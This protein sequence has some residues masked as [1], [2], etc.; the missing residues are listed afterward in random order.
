MKI[1]DLVIRA[2]T[3]HELVPGIIVDEEFEVVTAD[4]EEHSYESCN[5]IVQWSDGA[6]SKEMY[7]E[8]DYL[9]DVLDP[10]SLYNIIEGKNK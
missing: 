10:T 4:N 9:E 6:Q 3:W 2:Y 5:F 8:L 7:E 1:G